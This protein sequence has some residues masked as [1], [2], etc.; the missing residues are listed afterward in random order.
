MGQN[1]HTV[2][3]TQMKINKMF[4]SMVVAIKQDISI[5][6]RAAFIVRASATNDENEIYLFFIR[7]HSFG[8]KSVLIQRDTL[9]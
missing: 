2:A 4:L 6:L 3:M 7:F 5:Q 1:H 8:M 9:S